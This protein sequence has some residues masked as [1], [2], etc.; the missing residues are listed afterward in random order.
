[1]NHP[2][3]G[4]RILELRKAKGFTQEE[5]VDKCNLS[6]RTLQRIE[7][8]EASP[9]KY[10]IKSLL[11]ALDC[12]DS[13]FLNIKSPTIGFRIWLE[14]CFRYLLDLFNL[15]T[16]TMK[17]L[18]VLTLCGAAI[19]LG[20]TL[21]NNKS[22][23]QSD[24]STTVV[25][26]TNDTDS[27]IIRIRGTYNGWDEKNE[28][29]GRDVK[30]T[31]NGIQFNVNLLTID[32]KTMEFRSFVN[33]TIGLNDIEIKCLLEDLDNGLLKFNSDKITKL[34]S[35]LILTGN[36]Q[37]VSA[38]NETIKAGKIILLAEK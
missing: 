7:S 32:K 15:K 19:I 10:T 29:A 11:V 26:N 12:N 1:M 14:Q 37:L 21:V 25:L 20:L 3:L 2:E 36:A 22:H 5:L 23:A 31:V 24:D 35:K 6:V 18:S 30:C 8:G 34:D 13:D 38:K 4:R 9:R 33:G 28:F 27:N 16:N 17:K